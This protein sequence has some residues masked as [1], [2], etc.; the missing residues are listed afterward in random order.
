MRSD[1]Y[2]TAISEMT[3]PHKTPTNAK[4]IKRKDSNAD[5]ANAYTP[6]RKMS[7]LQG[8]GGKPSVHKRTNSTH[9]AKKL[10]AQAL[11]IK[12]LASL[13]RLLAPHPGVLK[14][15]SHV[16]SHENLGIAAKV[17]Q[18]PSSQSQVQLFT[19]RATM[20]DKYQTGT[21][22]LK[23]N[24]PVSMQK[25]ASITQKKSSSF[26]LQQDFMSSR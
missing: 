2:L 25:A 24:L 6:N 14:G 7:D 18:T 1:V 22:T 13:H 12:N 11:P 5:I 20:N 21:G 15:S 3:K 9:G 16:A 17:A 19:T 10:L 4:K 23:I 26:N 8:S